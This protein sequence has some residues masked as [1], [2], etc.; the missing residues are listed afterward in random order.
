M[1]ANYFEVPGVGTLILLV[2]PVVKLAGLPVL[3]SSNTPPA[4]TGILIAK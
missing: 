2:A 4:D 1:N 3:V